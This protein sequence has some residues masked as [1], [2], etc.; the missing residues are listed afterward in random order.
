MVEKLSYKNNL[1]L[2]NMIGFLHIDS[3]KLAR[4][5]R[6]LTSRAT[7][8]GNNLPSIAWVPKYVTA[9]CHDHVV[10]LIIVHVIA[11]CAFYWLILIFVVFCLIRQSFGYFMMIFVRPT[12]GV[13]LRYSSLKGMTG[14]T[15][16]GWT[17]FSPSSQKAFRLFS[18]CYFSKLIISS[19]NNSSHFFHRCNA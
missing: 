11:N 3:L 10:I 9:A 7:T 5:Y 1:L 2:K 13:G 16:A 19:K 4:S 8:V 12:P 17:W 15:G 18:T 14:S 6:S